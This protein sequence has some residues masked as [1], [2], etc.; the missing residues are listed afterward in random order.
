MKTEHE[1]AELERRAFKAYLKRCIKQAAGIS[2]KDGGPLVKLWL[3]GAFKWVEGR[4]A[5]YKK[6]KGGL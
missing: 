5:R 3:E 6:R 1:G 2:Q 4:S